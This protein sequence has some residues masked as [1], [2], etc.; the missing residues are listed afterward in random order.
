MDSAIETARWT[1]AV[2]ARENRRPDRIFEDPWAEVLAGDAIADE[3]P[4]AVIRT[5]FFD[6]FLARATAGQGIRQ[7]VL[8]ASGMDARAYRRLWPDGTCVYELDR[9]ELLELK[10]RLLREAGAR[11]TCARQSV[12]VDLTERWTAALEEAGFDSSTPSAWLA[13]GF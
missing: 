3:S 1:A 6:E 13:E 12:G 9:P 5:R 2:R 4:N 11:P 8:V 10:D 7:I